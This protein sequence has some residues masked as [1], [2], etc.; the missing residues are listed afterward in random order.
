MCTSIRLKGK[1]TYFGRNMDIECSFGESVVLAPRNFKIDFKKE[2]SIDSHYAILG[3]AALVDGYPLYA[4][5]F[6]EKGLCIAGLNFPRNTRYISID[7]S[8]SEKR[9]I[10]PYELPLFLLSQCKSV[11]ECVSILK[12][13]EITDIDFNDRVKVTD[14]H[15]HIADKRSSI[16]VECLER[17]MAVTEN[18]AN[19]LTNNPQLEMQIQSLAAYQ[20]LT[21][22]PPKN[23]LSEIFDLEGIGK[24]FGS[25]GLPGDF[26]SPSRFVKAA[27]LT[28]L[29][30]MLPEEDVGIPQLFSILHSVSVPKGSVVGRDGTHYTTYTCGIDAENKSYSIAY[31]DTL[32]FRSV[33]MLEEE[34]DLS[35]IITK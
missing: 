25:L 8:N 6:N 1:N 23:R 24:G 11:E 12:N 16:A 32:S 28:A 19:V 20:N 10:A 34:L 13:T 33:Y 2:K 5:A 35:E 29:S 15:W 31:S 26:S 9:K 22:N 7:K 14:L 30:D 3:T 21:P 17:G 4:D 18:K 27:Y